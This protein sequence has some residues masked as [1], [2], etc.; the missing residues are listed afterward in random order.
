ML[1]KLQVAT[2]AFEAA[3]K[4]LRDAEDALEKE[5]QVQQ[6]CGVELP[7]D[8]DGLTADGPLQPFYKAR[9]Q[10]SEGLQSCEQQLD[11]SKQEL[12]T[13]RTNCKAKWTKLRLYWTKGLPWTAPE[14]RNLYIAGLPIVAA[15]LL[16]SSSDSGDS[17]AN[18]STEP[19]PYDAVVTEQETACWDDKILQVATVVVLTGADGGVFVKRELYN[20]GESSSI[21]EGAH[22][23]SEALQRLEEAALAYR[24]WES[25]SKL[26]QLP[27]VPIN[28]SIY[29]SLMNS[30]PPEQQSVATVVHCLLE[31]VV[32]AVGS[33]QADTTHDA[34]EV[35]Q[36]RNFVE[37]ALARGKAI[38]LLTASPKVQVAHFVSVMEGD[39]PRMRS[40]GLISG[41][42]KRNVPGIPSTTHTWLK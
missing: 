24:G 4:K 23:M 9:H 41:L 31:E 15:M 19:C 16:R 10:C 25:D 20:E 39:E 27:E 34:W 22:E 7:T 14:L 1:E 29:H 12:S 8:T 30:I 17:T 26:M 5:Q 6:E 3:V 28:L 2:E 33:A 18:A 35:R 36:A 11:R 40:H 38:S 37:D 21:L 42:V 32:C 13:A